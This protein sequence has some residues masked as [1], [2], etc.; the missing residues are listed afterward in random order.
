MVC[1][2]CIRSKVRII[3]RPKGP[4]A[5]LFESL[6]KVA[7]KG[8]S[9]RNHSNAEVLRPRVCSNVVGFHGRGFI[10]MSWVRQ[11]RVYRIVHW[12]FTHDF[13]RFVTQVQ[14]RWHLVGLC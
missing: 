3:C 5:V 11:P 14:W 4:K 8:S 10:G 2:A 12:R 13:S 7:Q 1:I 6:P 9:T